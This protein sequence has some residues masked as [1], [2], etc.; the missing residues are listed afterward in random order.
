MKVKWGEDG[1]SREA[2]FTCRCVIVYADLQYKACDSFKRAV[3]R[4]KLF[5][6]AIVNLR[7]D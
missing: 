6:P 1:E 4:Y 2:P 3:A 7:F 5:V